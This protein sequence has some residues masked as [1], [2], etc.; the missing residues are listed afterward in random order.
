MRYK[1]ISSRTFLTIV[2]VPLF[3]LIS[4]L[5]AAA[6][7]FRMDE[8]FLRTMLQRDTIQP[9]FRVRMNENGPLHPLD[10]DCEMHIAGTVED[11][12]LGIPPAIVVEFPNWCRFSPD[13]QLPTNFQTLPTTWRNLVRNNVIDRTCEVK[14]FLRIFCEHCVG[15]QSGSS[16]PDHAYEF[17]PALSMRCGSRS[18][19]FGNMQSLSGAE[20]HR[21]LDGG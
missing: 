9:V 18:F 21:A 15:G 3:I 1:L 10:E 7:S 11:A 6:Q 13:G 5:T 16:N 14:G 19:S 12:S 17:H 4:T 2:L 8:S 20:T